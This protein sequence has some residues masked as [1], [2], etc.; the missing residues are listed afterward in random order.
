MYIKYLSVPQLD[1]GLR[2]FVLRQALRG[3]II[4]ETKWTRTEDPTAVLSW[5]QVSHPY[6]PVP[7]TWKRP[8]F[9]TN[10]VL[11]LTKKRNSQFS[12]WRPSYQDKWSSRLCFWSLPISSRGT[13]S[14]SSLFFHKS[15]LLLFI[16][17]NC[18]RESTLRVSAGE[19]AGSRHF[20]KVALP[21]NK[22]KAPQKKGL[23]LKR[24]WEKPGVCLFTCVHELTS[25]NSWHF[26]LGRGQNN[27]T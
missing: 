12:R 19:G 26:S 23:F 16:G 20:R 22:N 4:S 10:P 9:L 1:S 3:I 5:T 14:S 13:S 27:N 17:K 24:P 6:H 2:L 18:G 8:G 7:F 15:P 21:N 11:H 25:S